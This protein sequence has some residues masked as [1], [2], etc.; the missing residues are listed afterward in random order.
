MYTDSRSGR[1]E[2]ECIR[3]IYPSI[4]VMYRPAP[5]TSRPL[6][7]FPLPAPGR[8]GKGTGGEGEKEERNER[9]GE[10]DQREEKGRKRSE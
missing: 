5:D 3:G 1:V 9:G 4:R 2:G 6:T 7:I 10:E 8:E